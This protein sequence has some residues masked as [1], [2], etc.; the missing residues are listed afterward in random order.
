[1]IDRIIDEIKTKST[2]IYITIL[3]VFVYYL[4]VKF[5]GLVAL[6]GETMYQSIIAL[7]PHLGS[8]LMAVILLATIMYFL[9]LSDKKSKERIDEYDKPLKVESEGKGYISA[10]LIERYGKLNNTEGEIL[11]V[12][13]KNESDKDIDYIKG[14][15]VLYK[16]FTRISK[17][18]FEFD[19]LREVYSERIFYNFVDHKKLFW[20]GFDI[21]VSE[22]QFNEKT[23]RNF[24]IRGNHFVRTHYF[25]LN[26]NK[27]YDFKILGIRTRYN[28]VWLKEK[29][30]KEILVRVRHFCSKR[31]IYFHRRLF[32]LELRD[33][34]LRYLR[35]ILVVLVLLIIL[36]AIVLLLIDIIKALGILF[37]IWKEYFR[38]IVNL[39]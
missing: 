21:Y 20:D 5:W 34:I 8:I 17:I 19:N 18:P 10:K 14:Y 24:A 6:T 7:V 23:E 15:V 1:M 36:L 37:V 29:I 26:L 25:V 28:L 11:E 31:V 35:V 12:I 30:K 9:K 13:I 27:F 16:Q 4:V 3:L 2:Y 32:F 39:I 33:R 38:Q 22:I